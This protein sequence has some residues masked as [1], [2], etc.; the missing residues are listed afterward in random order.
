MAFL[1]GYRV[2]DLTDER[3]LLAGRLLADLGADV[4]AVEPPGGSAAR[5]CP[6]FLGGP[7]GRQ[8]LLWDT[9]AANK[10]GVEADLATGRGRAFVRRLADAADFL[11]ESAR[12]GVM[13]QLGLD[14]PDLKAVNPRLV[15]VSV[16]A[17]GRTGPK[18]GYADSDLVVWAAGGPLDPHRDPR[19]GPVRISLPQAFLH[20]AADAAA[21][22]RQ[23]SRATSRPARPRAFDRIIAT[24][25]PGDSVA[26]AAWQRRSLI[27]EPVPSIP[28]PRRLLHQ[29]PA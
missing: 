5:S 10:R 19:R 21:D 3:G 2:L 16:T 7:G 11:I 23:N 8:S 9:Y 1:D 28:Q 26:A 18:A 13:Q 6:P 24:I 17:F 12:P 4:V 14:W 25:L 27:C 20:A 29:R 15:Y 22:A